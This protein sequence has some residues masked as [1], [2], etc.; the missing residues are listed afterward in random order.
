M[1][2]FYIERL[3]FELLDYRGRGFKIKVGDSELEF[4]EDPYNRKPFYHFAFNIPSNQFK[5]AKDWAKS[6]VTLNTEDS[7]DEVYFKYSDAHSFYFL[8]P[9]ENIVE[10]ISRQS[11]SPKSNNSYSPTT[12]L[13][14]SEVNITSKD[15][16]SDGNKLIDF[17]IPVR[18]ENPLNENFNF[19][20]NNGAFLLLGKEKRKWFFS[21]KEAAIH[22]LSIEI[23]KRKIITLDG[24]GDIKFDLLH[25]E[26]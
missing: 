15:V 23:D 25:L 1:K 3:G 10:F 6:K 7:A 19:M 4:Q 18:D 17:G 13:D 22:P 11:I 26:K 12:I 2:D 21:N 9:S 14:I 20:G 24:L 5:E 16:L 8:D